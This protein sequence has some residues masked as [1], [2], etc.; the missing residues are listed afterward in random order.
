M[1]KTKSA[2]LQG[3]IIKISGPVVVASKLKG[4]QMYE[5]VRVGNEGLIGEVIELEK[6]QATIQV[7]EETTGIAPGSVVHTTGA[8]LSVQ[9]GPGVLGNIYDGIQRPLE[10]IK[11]QSGAFIARG[12]AADAGSTGG[13]RRP[14]RR[15]VH[16]RGHGRRPGPELLGASAAAGDDPSRL[17]A[18][19]NAGRAG[20]VSGRLGRSRHKI[21]PPP[22]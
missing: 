5:V 12:L 8:S 15:R 17:R 4:V 11:K 6:D 18:D 14:A 7:Y 10:L 22:T 9:L 3:K 20:A 16:L 1:I 19:C 2:Q 13:L 21:Y